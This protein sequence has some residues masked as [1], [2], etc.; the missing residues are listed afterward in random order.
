M[1]EIIHLNI[2]SYVYSDKELSAR[3][4]DGLQVF[5]NSIIDSFTEK[6]NLY[7]KFQDLINKQNKCIR[8]LNNNTLIQ[9]YCK[10]TVNFIEQLLRELYYE[11]HKGESYV[12]KESL[13]L[14][15][16]LNSN[17]NMFESKLKKDFLDGIRFYLSH[18]TNSKGEHVGLDLRNKMNHGLAMSN[19][20]YNQTLFMRISLLFITLINELYITFTIEV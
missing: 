20:D 9:D 4:F 1:L 2:L 18:D 6:K 13:T 8:D 11:L 16:L 5:F 7:I 19:S 3:L 12:D 10:N 15:M 14:G 17:N